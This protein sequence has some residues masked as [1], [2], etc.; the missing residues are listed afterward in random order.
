M[1]NFECID[2]D[3][4]HR[5]ECGLDPKH[6][7]KSTIAANILGYGEISTIFEINH[8]S[9]SGLA[10]KRMPI[11]TSLEELERYERLFLEYNRLLSQ[12]IGI[13]VPAHASARIVPGSGNMVIYNIQEKLPFGSFCH[14][15]IHRL[16]VVTSARLFRLILRAMKR[17]WEFN[18]GDTGVII[19]LDGQLS[20]WAL[21]NCGDG[22]ASLPENESGLYYIDTSTPLMRVQGKEQLQADLFLRS[23]PSFLVGIIKTFF[24]QGILDRYYDFRL[25]ALDLIAN[26]NKEQRPDLIPLFVQTANDFFATEAPRFCSSPITEKEV[27]DYYRLDS[28]FFSLFLAFRRLDRFIST[29]LLRIPYPYILPGNIKR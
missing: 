3:L 15:L 29:R 7:E 17:V 10:F 25:V 20:N 1:G 16:D 11:F 22:T 27:K 4:L 21:K 14:E 24:L 13:A 19:G 23:V 9:Q 5:F 8:E 18:A 2:T 26:L 28:A 6:P 12:E